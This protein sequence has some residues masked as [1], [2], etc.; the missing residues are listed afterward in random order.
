MTL[1]WSAAFIGIP[2]VPLGRS[3]AGADCWGL[4]VLVYGAMHR[5]ALPS[6]AEDYGDPDNFQAANAIIAGRLSA[7]P[8]TRLSPQAGPPQEFDLAVFARGR[9]DS[10]IGIVVEPGTMLH[11]EARD[12]AKIARFDR[13]VWAPRLSCYLRHK[14]IGGAP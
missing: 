13:G 7:D 11:M 10:H 14:A 2:E 12:C 4:A 8:W 5:I 9:L 1:H 6:F 3:R